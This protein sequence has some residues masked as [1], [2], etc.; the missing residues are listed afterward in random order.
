MR[1][2]VIYLLEMRLATSGISEAH[3]PLHGVRVGFEEIISFLDALAEG[4]ED[5][6]RL[7]K[8]FECIDGTVAAIEEQLRRAA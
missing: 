6:D 5:R 3:M 1:Q 8:L 2:G 7:S 4:G